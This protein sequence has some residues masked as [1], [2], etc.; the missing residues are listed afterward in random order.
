L[1]FQYPVIVVVEDNFTNEFMAQ[2]IE[3]ILFEITFE[4]VVFNK[5]DD[6]R[7]ENVLVTHG[8]HHK[9]PL[10]YR[11]M[12][13]FWTGGF[14]DY[15]PLKQYRYIWRMDSD[16]YIKQGIEYDLFD[17][18]KQNSIAYT[19]SNVYDDE[20]EVCEGL[21]DFSK[22]FFEEKSMPFHWDLYKMF[23]THVEIIDT[24][25]FRN[26]LYHEFYKRVDE[27][28]YFYLRRW[29]DAPIRFITLTNMGL[30]CD[31][32][33]ISYYHGNDGSGR[34]EQLLVMNAQN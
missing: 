9:W 12:C 19:F 22:A 17:H 30:K 27:T 13:R 34:R 7:I 15:E 10:G 31:H 4:V 29:G 2:I 16:A 3:S 14:L 8:G 1:A 33:R 28:N 5:P 23:T 24:E 26:S 6:A 20:K 32:M 18:M 11:H 21:L 25:V